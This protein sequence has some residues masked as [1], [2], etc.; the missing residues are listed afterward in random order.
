MLLCSVKR[1]SGGDPDTPRLQDSLTVFI[2]DGI[3][4]LN[5][6]AGD[7]SGNEKWQ[8]ERIEVQPIAI[9]PAVVITS[10]AVQEP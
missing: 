2:K 9:F 1:I 7:R 3:G 10:H 5:I 4:R 6:Y 8:P